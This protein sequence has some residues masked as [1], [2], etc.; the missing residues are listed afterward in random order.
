MAIDGA[1]IARL[2]VWTP[3]QQRSIVAA[4]LAQHQREFLPGQLL[5]PWLVTLAWALP[6]RLWP[7]WLGST[8]PGALARVQ[9]HALEFAVVPGEDATERDD[10]LRRFTELTATLGLAELRTGGLGVRAARALRR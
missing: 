3:E 1:S 7:E 4:R 5:Q 8:E 6:A 10:L 2:A 9:A